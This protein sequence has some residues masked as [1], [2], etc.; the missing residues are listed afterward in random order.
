MKEGDVVYVEGTSCGFAEIVGP[1]FRKKT[2]IGDETCVPVLMLS[3]DDA[4]ELAIA[5]QSFVSEPEISERM[6]S[7]LN[8]KTDKI[9]K[10]EAMKVEMD[11]CDGC[12]KRVDDVHVEEGWIHLDGLQSISVSVRRNKEGRLL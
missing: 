1:P 11:Q 2:S 4:G 5:E 3:G 6:R 10:E 9:D 12:G 8:Q 7:L